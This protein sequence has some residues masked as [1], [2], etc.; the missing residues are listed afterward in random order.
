VITLATVV[1]VVALR[2]GDLAQFGRFVGLLEAQET[3]SADVQT[4]SHRTL[5]G[6]FGLRVFADHPVTGAGWQAS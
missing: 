6:Y 2:G 1:G 4:Y 5:L 3:T